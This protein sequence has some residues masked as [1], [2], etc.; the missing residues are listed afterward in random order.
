MTPD[1]LPPTAQ[2]VQYYGYSFLLSKTFWFGLATAAAGVL[3][4]PAVAALLPSFIAPLIP[5]RYLPAVLSIVGFLVIYLRTLSIR[6]IAAVWPS[7]VVP[8]DVPKIGPPPPSMG[9]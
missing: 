4:L 1:A 9:A 3:S 6:P 2:T 5:E 8:V 7:E